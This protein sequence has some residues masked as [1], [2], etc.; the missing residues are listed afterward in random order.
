MEQSACQRTQKVASCYGITIFVPFGTRHCGAIYI[1]GGRQ[2]VKCPHKNKMVDAKG[3][4]VST[5]ARVGSYVGLE[6]AVRIF[7]A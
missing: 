1:T 5:M 7:K 4:R 3:L 6:E 2:N